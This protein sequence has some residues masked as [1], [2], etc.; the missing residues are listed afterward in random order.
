MGRVIYGLTR[1]ELASA[2]RQA[3]AAWHLGNRQQAEILA[4]RKD[5]QRRQ[6]I[7]H[8]QAAMVAQQAVMLLLQSTAQQLLESC[9]LRPSVEPLVEIMHLHL[10][11]AA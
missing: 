2:P 7:T 1:S 11:L 8:S 5:Y 10:D 4:S 6:M 3:F 9:H